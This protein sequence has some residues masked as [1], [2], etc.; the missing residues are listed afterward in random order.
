MNIL[1]LERSVQDLEDALEM[2]HKNI[3]DSQVNI[4]DTQL[5][6]IFKEACLYNF[7]NTYEITL[8]MIKRYLKETS[9]NPLEIEKM[10][11]NQM[12]EKAFE[13]SILKSEL[14]EWKRFRDCRIKYAESYQKKIVNEILKEIPFFLKEVKY[15][16]G[17]L[18][19]KLAKEQQ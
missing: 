14:K 10:T 9:S 15:F 1:S 3:K 4:E 17:Y 7:K 6:N 11:F 16:M 8:K 19:K 13:E 5:R 18:N 2:C 12:I